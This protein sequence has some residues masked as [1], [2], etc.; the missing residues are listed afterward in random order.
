MWSAGHLVWDGGRYLGNFLGR[1]RLAVGS[2]LQRKKLLAVD[3]TVSCTALAVYDCS[4]RTTWPASC[5]CACLQT[6]VPSSLLVSTR[7]S[8]PSSMTL[9]KIC[10][11]SQVA[12]MVALK[13]PHSTPLTVQNQLPICAVRGCDMHIEHSCK[14]P[15]LSTTKR[16]DCIALTTWCCRIM[17]FQLL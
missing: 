2:K 16:V 4:S 7:R 17:L 13:V 14:R 8:E 3:A 9:D 5:V 1:L 11:V 10:S 6:I 15:N 12:C